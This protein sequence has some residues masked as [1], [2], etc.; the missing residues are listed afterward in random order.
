MYSQEAKKIRNDYFKAWR[1]KNKE[2]VNGYQRAWRAKNKDKV[3]EYNAR[4]WNNRA[5]QEG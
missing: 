2:K 5:E 1:S 4:Y 3:A